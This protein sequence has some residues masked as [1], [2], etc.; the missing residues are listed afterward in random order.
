MSQPPRFFTLAVEAG[1]ELSPD[2]F[3]Y[4]MGLPEDAASALVEKAI[5]RSGSGG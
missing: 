1:L 3:G 5:Q 4:L 2:A